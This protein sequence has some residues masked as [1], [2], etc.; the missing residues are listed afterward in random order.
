VG[1][2]TATCA[3]YA[4]QVQDSI[5][6]TNWDASYAI[7]VVT[8]EGSP[9]ANTLKAAPDRTLTVRHGKQA[10]FKSGSESSDVFRG[11][12]ITSDWIL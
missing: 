11:A 4:Y 1:N 7:D 2:R 10:L 5:A 3:N 6:A 12:K 9:E 8:L